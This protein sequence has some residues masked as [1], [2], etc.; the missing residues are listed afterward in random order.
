MLQFIR[1]YRWV[2]FAFAVSGVMILTIGFHWGA[3]AL[4]AA[5]ATHATGAY[6]VFEFGRLFQIERREMWQ[7]IQEDLEQLDDTWH[8]DTRGNQKP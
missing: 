2:A 6:T 7:Q 4:L 5:M 3:W 1:K 8:T